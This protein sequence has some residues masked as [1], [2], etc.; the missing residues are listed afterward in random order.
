[1]LYITNFEVSTALIM[2]THIIAL[3][4]KLYWK[5]TTFLLMRQN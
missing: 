1:M 5:T 4:L 2:S 3:K